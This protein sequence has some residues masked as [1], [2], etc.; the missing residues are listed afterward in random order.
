M[1]DQLVVA[2]VQL[3]DHVT[4]AIRPAPARA[5]AGAGE[6]TGFIF[7]KWQLRKTP[8]H[9][10]LEW[11]AWMAGWL[12]NQWALILIL[13]LMGPAQQAANPLVQDVVTSHW[14]WAGAGGYHPDA[15]FEHGSQRALF[16]GGSLWAWLTPTSHGYE[17]SGSWSSMATPCDTNSCACG[18][19]GA[20]RALY[21]HFAIQTEMYQKI[22]SQSQMA[23]VKSGMLTDPNLSVLGHIDNFSCICVFQNVG[24]GLLHSLAKHI[25]L[26]TS[27]FYFDF[28]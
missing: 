11:S 6:P 9:S 3:W 26:G 4:Q 20:C 7:Q 5:V 18:W 15:Q 13:C 25:L 16:V 21:I 23:V 19:Y 24:P 1:L 14:L 10:S 8:R 27:E 28:V 17:D 12:E 2:Q 22:V